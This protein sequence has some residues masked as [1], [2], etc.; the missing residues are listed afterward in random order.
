LEEKNKLNLQT[1]MLRFL[2]VVL[3]LL[4][5]VSGFTNLKTIARGILPA[6]GVGNFV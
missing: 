1:L 2:F 5:L 6:E 4:A 3:K